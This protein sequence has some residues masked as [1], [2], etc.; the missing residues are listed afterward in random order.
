MADSDDRVMDARSRAVAD[1]GTGLPGIDPAQRGLEADQRQLAAMR[2]ELEKEIR[3]LSDERTSS[4]WSG[5]EVPP[6][7][8]ERLDAAIK[9]LGR[10]PATPE[11]A[12]KDLQIAQSYEPDPDKL[13]KEW[14]EKQRVAYEAVALSAPRTVLLKAASLQSERATGDW[15]RSFAEPR[16]R[17]PRCVDPT[18]GGVQLQ[19]LRGEPRWLDL[20]PVIAEFQ[21]AKSVIVSVESLALAW[22]DRWKKQY[23][24][25]DY[26][27][28]CE[29]SHNRQQGQ[30]QDSKSQE[31][32][33]AESWRYW[34]GWVKVEAPE[35]APGQAAPKLP[36]GRYHAAQLAY[37]WAKEVITTGKEQR[38][39][40]WS[41]LVLGRQ[42]PPTV[43]ESTGLSLPGRFKPIEQDGFEKLNRRALELIRVL[44]EVIAAVDPK[45]LARHEASLAHCR[46][47]VS[48]WVWRDAQAEILAAF[49]PIPFRAGKEPWYERLHKGAAVTGPWSATYSVEMDE[50]LRNR[51]SEMFGQ[52]EAIVFQPQVIHFEHGKHELGA[53]GT[54]EVQAAIQALRK[55]SARLGGRALLVEVAGHADKTGDRYF[56]LELSASRAE[57]VADLLERSDKGTFLR[58][59]VAYGCGDEFAPDNADRPEYRTAVIRLNEVDL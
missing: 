2:D 1:R 15:A 57:R 32:S 41:D 22:C 23:T 5:V 36:A 33:T 17:T 24:G 30:R 34:Y 11:Q 3:E 14:E 21:E 12:I 45:F 6:T 10:L 16:R 19:E 39:E 51:I 27:R 44:A 59:V 37:M 38:P 29:E 53:Q 50:S 26:T 40:R 20:A 46:G 9:A 4:Q 28:T 43:G 54:A 7:N 55:V 8:N 25:V 52:Q 48:Q 58:G 31:T 47:L 13:G 49:G 18:V 56:N 35:T 42:E